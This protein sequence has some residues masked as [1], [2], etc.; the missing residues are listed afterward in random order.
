MIPC[1]VV[2]GVTAVVVADA[3]AVVGETEVNSFPAKSSMTDLF[4]P[5]VKCCYSF[6]AFGF[7]FLCRHSSGRRDLVT[8]FF[9]TLAVDILR[10]GS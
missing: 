3:V 10:V 9:V 7:L 4:V 1:V 6:V 8:T 5:D 2:A